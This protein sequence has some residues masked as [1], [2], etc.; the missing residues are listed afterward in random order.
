MRSLPGWDDLCWS[1]TCL[2]ALAWAF[3]LRIGIR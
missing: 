3:M 2:L 1:R